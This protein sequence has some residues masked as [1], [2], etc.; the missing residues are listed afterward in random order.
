MRDRARDRGAG[1]SAGRLGETNPVVP[2]FWFGADVGVG[3]GGDHDVPAH[4]ECGRADPT[5][6]LLAEVDDLA[7]VDLDPSP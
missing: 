3:D 5:A 4:M 1:S 2:S 7:V 6:A